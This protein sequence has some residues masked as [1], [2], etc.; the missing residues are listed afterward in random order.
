M[1]RRLAAVGGWLGLLLLGLAAVKPTLAERVVGVT[2]V[3]Y[4]GGELLVVWW[5]RESGVGAVGIGLALLRGALIMLL[6]GDGA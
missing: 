3:G 6:L 5:R 4:A 2:A 1:G